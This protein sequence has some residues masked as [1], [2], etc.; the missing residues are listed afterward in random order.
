MFIVTHCSLQQRVKRVRV[1]MHRDARGW[2]HGG[3]IAPLTFQ[4]SATGAEV[5]FHNSIIGNFMV[6]Q[7]RSETNLLQLFGH[8]ED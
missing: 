5:R 8:P 1:N 2:R 6:Y 4:K 7:D 3:G